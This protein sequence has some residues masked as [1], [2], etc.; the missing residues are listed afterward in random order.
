MKVLSH[1]VQSTHHFV[2]ETCF[3]QSNKDMLTVRLSPYDLY[4]SSDTALYTHVYHLIEAQCMV[5]YAPLIDYIK[6][7]DTQGVSEEEIWGFYAQL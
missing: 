5:S 2:V 7:I 1:V 6:V 4:Q 3:S